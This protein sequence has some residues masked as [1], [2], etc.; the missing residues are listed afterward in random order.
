MSD[1]D[2]P[3]DLRGVGKTYGKK[4][5]AL[6]GVDIR[7]RGGE[8]FGL[9]GPNGAGKSTL[10]KIITTVV[11]PDE[12]AGTIL[13]QPL[14]HKPTLR[15]IGYLPEDHRFPHYLTGAK[16][17][18]FYARLSK[19]PAAT[20]KARSAY[21]LDRMG[22]S[23]WANTRVGKY[24]KG[25][26][27][28]IG[29]AQALQHDPDLVLLD[30]P[31]D[32]VDP[33]G[34]KQIREIMLELKQAG[35][36]VFINSHILSELEMVCDRVAILVEGRVARQGTVEELTAH[37][38]TYDVT[39]V[40]DLSAVHG[41]IKQLNAQVNERTITIQV[42]G[43][44]QN[45]ATVNCQAGEKVIGGGASW[46]ELNTTTSLLQSHRVGNGWNAGG[47]TTNNTRQLTIK[48]YC[49]EV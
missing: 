46:D 15:R 3:I 21:W 19:V 43:G 18:D 32:G 39:V 45:D 47:K 9:L 14:G 23:K 24:S 17:L 4:I 29:I 34:R 30:E 7:V 37:S 5:K 44:T 8:I 31:T 42:N 1:S 27:Q 36:T 20:R 25:M 26:L 13:G 38:L 11:L 10:V 6:R 28:R 40:N 33:I 12:A 2:W 35:K 22:M 49:L 41:E 16:V 48:A